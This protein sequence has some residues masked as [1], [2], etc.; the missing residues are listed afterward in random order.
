MRTR[1]DASGA[2]ICARRRAPHHP[3]GSRHP[4][5][6]PEAF[7]PLRRED[8]LPRG[9]HRA[10][11]PGRSHVRGCRGS[12]AR[13]P[14]LRDGDPLGRQ[15][16]QR[17]YYAFARKP[18]APSEDDA[19][20]NDENDAIASFY[21]AATNASDDEW[22]LCDDSSVRRVNRAD[23]FDEQAYVLFY[24]RDEEEAPPL[25]RR[26]PEPLGTTSARTPKTVR[27]PSP[28]VV[29][30]DDDD[31]LGRDTDDDDDAADADA[32]PVHLG[33]AIGPTGPPRGHPAAG[34]IPPGPDERRPRRSVTLG[35]GEGDAGDGDGGDGMTPTLMAPTTGTTPRR[36]ADAPLDDRPAV[37]DGVD[38]G[39]GDGD[40]R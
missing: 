20:K 38:D 9:L 35:D 12:R 37:D 11:H 18:T 23:V 14:A 34:K 13:V 8:Q 40:G 33:D 17:H 31:G 7:R 32:D 15:R 22:Y 3:R 19:G 6:P 10:T 29:D 30:D 21:G 4:R 1:T 39:D 26:R 27:T 24:E 5:G 16:Q 25:T 28:P 36:R 2:K